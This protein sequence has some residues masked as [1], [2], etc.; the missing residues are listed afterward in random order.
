MSLSR[1]RF[2]LGYDGTAYA[3]WQVQPGHATVQGVLEHALQILDGAPVKAH[4]SGRTDRGVHAVGQVAHADLAR[5]WRAPDILRALNTELPPDIRVFRAT[6]AKQN[7]H[8][9]RDATAKEYRY[10]IWDGPVMPPELRLYR[11]FAARPLNTDAMRQAAS[12][13]VGKHDFAAFAA[14]PNREVAST[15]RTLLLLDVRRR[16]HD[17]TIRA[18]A[19]GFLY[20]MVRSLTGFLIRVGEGALRPEAGPA[21]LAARKRTAVA[22]T[23][24]PQGLFLWRVWY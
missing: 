22:P 12:L 23:A 14:N 13:L 4:G 2:V 17:V 10:C 8:A 6:K 20:R 24:P 9:R 11:T 5:S 7:F 15:I 18:R 1:Y 16:G 3:G 21:L 19:D